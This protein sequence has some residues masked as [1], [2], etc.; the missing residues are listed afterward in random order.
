MV[1]QR[2]ESESRGRGRA[3]TVGPAVRLALLFVSGA[4]CLS[5]LLALASHILEQGYSA[6]ESPVITVQ[7]EDW[8]NTTAS[9][10]LQRAANV[11]K[12]GYRTVP[13]VFANTFFLHSDSILSEFSFQACCYLLICFLL[14]AFCFS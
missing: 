3:V 13:D 6:K 7:E 2:S 4:A 12:S 5:V 14:S 11:L 10:V 8:A 1:V 9:I